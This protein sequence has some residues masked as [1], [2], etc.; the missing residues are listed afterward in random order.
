M[1]SSTRSTLLAYQD[2]PRRYL[3]QKWHLPELISRLRPACQIGSRYMGFPKSFR[4]FRLWSCSSFPFGN[5]KVLSMFLLT[6]RWPLPW[7]TTGSPVLLISSQGYIYWVTKCKSWLTIPLTNCKYRS[8]AFLSNLKPLSAFQFLLYGNQHRKM[9]K[10]KKEWW[11][12]EN[13]MIWWCQTH[14][15]FFSNQKS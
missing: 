15:L 8:D 7:K 11:I 2:N 1:L 5:L 4:S 13:S 3:I 9:N 14:A 10:K 12:S 6:N